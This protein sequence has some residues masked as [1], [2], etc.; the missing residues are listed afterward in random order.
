[1]TV[2]NLVDVHCHIDLF[3]KPPEIVRRSEENSIYTIA[4][5]NAPFVFRNTERLTIGCKFVRAA[6]G[7]HP[8]LVHSHGEQLADLRELIRKTRYVGEIGLD[9]SDSDKSVR[10][11]QRAIL[12]TVLDWCAQEKNKILTVHSRRAVKDVIS[13]IGSDY[14]GKVILHW[15]TGDADELEISASLGHYFSVNG[16]MLSS[17]SGR[18]IARQIPLDKILTES[19]G[20]FAK[21]A[22]KVLTPES[23]LSTLGDLASI[24]NLPLDIV[25]AQ[26]FSNFKNLLGTA[27][28]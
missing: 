13:V 2:A 27:L 14:P 22:G 25:R 6:A 17:S 8:E 9:Y 20:P 1:M 7:L 5:T 16:A 12:T 28:G 26:V 23:V 24:L 10:R 11:E 3:D 15:F 4:V 21:V 19:D 18:A